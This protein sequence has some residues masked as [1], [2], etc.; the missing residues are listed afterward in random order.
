M[1]PLLAAVVAALLLLTPPALA[2]PRPD[3]TCDYGTQR[4]AH[5]ASVCEHTT[6]SQGMEPMLAV[7]KRGTLFMG[8]ATDKGLYE[9][10]GA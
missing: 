6:G 3:P 8:I 1:A 4:T 7:D 9:D 5:G 2:A 10:P